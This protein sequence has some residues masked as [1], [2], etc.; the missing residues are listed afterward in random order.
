MLEVLACGHQSKTTQEMFLR[1]F[2][3]I[4]QV[5][6]LFVASYLLLCFGGVSS[7]CFVLFR[8]TS[9]ADREV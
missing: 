5:G 2:F 8:Y 6:L 1:D 9:C 7:C 4:V 3:H